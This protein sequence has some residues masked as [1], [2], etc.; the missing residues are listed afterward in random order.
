M[1]QGSP[2]AR[3]AAAHRRRRVPWFALAALALVALA[4][5]LR[6]LYVDATPDYVLRHDAIAYE[7]HA[8][9]IA[10]GEGYSRRVAYGRPTA[11]RPPGYPYFLA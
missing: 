3:A 9:S 4:L 8:Q 5:V 6:L 11:F 7:R 2:E 10:V 1:F